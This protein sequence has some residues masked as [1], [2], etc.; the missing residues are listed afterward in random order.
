MAG[1]KVV[2]TTNDKQHAFGKW[3]T[4]KKKNICSKWTKNIKKKVVWN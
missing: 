1:W 4:V 2:N 3:L